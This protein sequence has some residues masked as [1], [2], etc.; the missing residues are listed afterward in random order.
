MLERLEPVT[1]CDQFPHLRFH[2]PEHESVGESLNVTLDR[3]IEDFGLN[4]I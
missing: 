2:Q 3:L 1:I 4:T